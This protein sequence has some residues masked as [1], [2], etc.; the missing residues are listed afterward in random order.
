VAAMEFSFFI[1][2]TIAYLKQGYAGRKE[3]SG[4]EL[5]NLFK[6]FKYS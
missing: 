1:C 2:I 6:H 4:D 5:G 3:Y